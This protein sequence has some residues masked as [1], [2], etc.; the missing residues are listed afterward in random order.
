MSDDVELGL[1][2]PGVS[3]S[4][5][6]TTYG[7]SKIHRGY[8]A[9]R[10]PL[11]N[12][13]GAGF[14]AGQN[15]QRIF[16]G[17]LG[18]AAADPRN[19]V[20]DWFYNL[21]YGSKSAPSSPNLERSPEAEEVKSGHVLPFSKNI[22]P[23]NSIQPALTRADAIAQGHDLHYKYAK[24]DSDVLSADREAISQFANEFVNPENPVSQLQAAIGFVGLGAKHGVESLS[25]KV[26][27]GK[28]VFTF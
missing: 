16:E 11:K 4:S 20:G 25:G 28:Y 24:K 12:S 6:S 17:Q 27:Y 22:G 21:F 14:A 8:G 7:S 26:F 3:S 2:L 13:S 19:P 1:L 9:S 5:G 15:Y 18:S 10:I 23:G